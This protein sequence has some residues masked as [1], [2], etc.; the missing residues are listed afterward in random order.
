MD[1]NT[2]LQT[3]S[4]LGF[5]SSIWLSGIYYSQSHLTIPLLYALAEDTSASIFQ[6]LYY[7]GAKLIVPIVLTSVLSSGTSAYLDR[8]KRVPYAIAALATIGTLIWTRAVM[9]GGIE[10]LIAL[11][12]KE[13]LREKM[14]PGEVVKLL[15][16]WR[17]MNM[18]RAALA[19]IGGI[20][21]LLGA[22]GIL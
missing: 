16:Q 2:I 17:W 14:Q 22:S 18:V 20:V 6:G 21:G 8:E 7:S 19:G 12:N 11:A 13:R 1:S 15:K 9:M 5:T 10:R 3:T 4:F